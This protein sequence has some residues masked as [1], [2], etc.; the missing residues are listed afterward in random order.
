MDLFNSTLTSRDGH[1]LHGQLWSSSTQK[2]WSKIYF[3]SN[4]DF[5]LD[6]GHRLI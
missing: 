3:C 4:C 5:S 2:F 6:S 1:T